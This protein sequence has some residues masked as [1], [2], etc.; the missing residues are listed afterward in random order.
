MDHVNTF[1][2]GSGASIFLII[3]LLVFTVSYL[4]GHLPPTLLEIMT[5]LVGALLMITAGALAVYQS[6]LDEEDGVRFSD[7]SVITLLSF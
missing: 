2:Y 1:F 7:K 3:T 6:S 4:L 5:T